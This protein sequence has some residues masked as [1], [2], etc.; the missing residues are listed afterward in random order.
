[1]ANKVPE[2]G[3]WVRFR[4]NGT[5]VIGVVQYVHDGVPYS[6]RKSYDTDL[7]RVDQDA[8]LEVR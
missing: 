7:G 2:V 3:D 4:K 8:V 6:G 1:M 5:L